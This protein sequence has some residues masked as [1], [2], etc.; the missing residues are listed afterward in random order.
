MAGFR[1]RTG[2]TPGWTAGMQEGQIVSVC[3]SMSDEKYGSQ[4]FNW[5]RVFSD[6]VLKDIDY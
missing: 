3:G 1:D 4:D 6:H 5:C 2:Y